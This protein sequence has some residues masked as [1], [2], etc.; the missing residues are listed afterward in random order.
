MLPA[1]QYQLD[2]TPIGLVPLDTIIVV[3]IT[4][5]GDHRRIVCKM[6]CVWMFGALS[7]L[8]AELIIIVFLPSPRARVSG[9][10]SE[11]KL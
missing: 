6:G 9:K 4:V 8:A 7:T 10:A 3:M 1:V 2:D 11:K 5:S